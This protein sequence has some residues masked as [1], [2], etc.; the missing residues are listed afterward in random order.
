MGAFSPG[1]CVLALQ[2]HCK[3]LKISAALRPLVDR[4]VLKGAMKVFRRDG[5]GAT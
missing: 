4:K 3:M 1:F 5:F 2:A